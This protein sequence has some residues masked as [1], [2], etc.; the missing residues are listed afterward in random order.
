MYGGEKAKEQQQVEHSQ[1]MSEDIKWKPSSDE[2]Q[3][4]WHWFWYF[5]DGLPTM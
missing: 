1:Q 3:T 4:T 5:F 2:D